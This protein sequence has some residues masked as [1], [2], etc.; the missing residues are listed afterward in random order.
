MEHKHIENKT[1]EVGF[2]ARSSEYPA[3]PL[4]AAQLAPPFFLVSCL[5]FDPEDGGNIFL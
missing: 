2:G 3:S 5:F 1:H 4:H